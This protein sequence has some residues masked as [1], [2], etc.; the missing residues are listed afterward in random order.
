MASFLILFIIGNIIGGVLYKFIPKLNENL[1]L[2]NKSKEELSEPVKTNYSE[3]VL[4]LASYNFS[5]TFSS[6]YYYSELEDVTPQIDK[7]LRKYKKLF[8]DDIFSAQDASEFSANMYIHS[9]QIQNLFTTKSGIYTSKSSF[10]NLI[11]LKECLDYVFTLNMSEEAFSVV[12]TIYYDFLYNLIKDLYLF[13]KKLPDDSSIKKELIYLFQDKKEKDILKD[14]KQ[15]LK[16][17][18]AIKDEYKIKNLDSHFKSS[19][20]VHT[21]LK[22]ISNT[23]DDTL[24]SPDNIDNLEFKVTANSIKN[25]IIPKVKTY[26]EQQTSDDTLAEETLDKILQI[27]SQNKTQDV[28]DINNELKVVNRYLDTLNKKDSHERWLR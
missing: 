28:S 10:K 18:T 17:C 16:I 12:N 19:S 22:S 23:L 3:D 11:D 6:F 7:D 25:E 5:N 20:S 9:K 8:I 1:R 14:C 21:K 27:I 2:I 15:N 24:N 26:Y 13:R 4:F